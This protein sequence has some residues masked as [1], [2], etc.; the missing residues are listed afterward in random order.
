MYSLIRF[1]GVAVAL[2]YLVYSSASA[3]AQS[4]TEAASETYGSEAPREVRYGVG[5]NVRGLMMP[6]WT[7]KLTNRDWVAVSGMKN[8]GIGVNVVRRGHRGELAL[9]IGYERLGAEDA[10][11][12]DDGGY[13]SAQGCCPDLVEF[14]NFSWI[15]AD[16]TATGI[17]SLTASDGLALRYGVGLGVGIF[18]GEILRTRYLCPLGRLDL[19][20]CHI[21]PN[22]RERVREPKDGIPPAVPLVNAFAGI[23]L[24]PSSRLA[25]NLDTG[26]RW[27]FYSNLSV[28]YLIGR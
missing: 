24:R 19:E 11:W 22:P 27:A 2:G 5:L 16:L 23:Q 18:Q 9:G 21:H 3:R 12:L 17:R 20:E 25:V 10:L 28:I 14:E 13:L 6:E 26:F 8:L 4:P 1:A 15:S 7:V